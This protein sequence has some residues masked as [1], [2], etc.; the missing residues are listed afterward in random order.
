MAAEAERYILT[1]EKAA[2]I[3]SVVSALLED[4]ECDGEVARRARE[5][6][7]EFMELECDRLLLDLRRVA[8]PPDGV[9]PPVKNVRASLLG[10]VLVI[11]G[12][13]TD[14]EVFRQIEAVG[15]LHSS[16]KQR[17]TEFRSYAHA[18]GAA[19]TDSTR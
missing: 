3:R 9:S 5:R 2:R 19:A 18:L 11:T 1:A 15:A 10:R 13:V 7:D 17:I 6:L 14:P 16:P 12:E 8:V 4:V